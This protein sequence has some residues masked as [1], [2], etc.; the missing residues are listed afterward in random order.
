MNLLYANTK[1]LCPVVC[2]FLECRSVPFRSEILPQVKKQDDTFEWGQSDAELNPVL[3]NQTVKGKSNHSEWAV[4]IFFSK[5]NFFFF[6][7]LFFFL[8]MMSR[9]YHT[10]CKSISIQH[11]AQRKTFTEHE[12]TRVRT[13]SGA[14]IGKLNWGDGIL[15]IELA[16]SGGFGGG[17]KKN[18]WA[19]IHDNV[20]EW[21]WREWE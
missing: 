12:S 5:C 20:M 7:S 14:V 2:T 3:Q 13:E 19:W 6:T 11:P 18:E 21:H 10:S 17:R 16:A 8:M 1:S 9:S 4:K 15:L